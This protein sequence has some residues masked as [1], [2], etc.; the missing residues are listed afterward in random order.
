MN[1]HFAVFVCLS[2]CLIYK[3][4]ELISLKFGITEIYTQICVLL[5]SLL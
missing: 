2:A 5:S 4:S 1:S 3:A